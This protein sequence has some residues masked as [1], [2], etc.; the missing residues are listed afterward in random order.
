[1]TIRNISLFTLFI[2][3][4]FG[5]F[6]ENSA[7]VDMLFEDTCRELKVRENVAK[8]LLHF[9]NNAGKD[10]VQS[11]FDLVRAFC[12]RRQIAYS[13]AKDPLLMKS[14]ISVLLGEP[15]KESDSGEWVYYFNN[16]RT[17]HI[18]L[19]FREQTL[20]YTHYRQLK[21]NL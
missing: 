19:E 1:M 10:D 11:D 21:R 8:I 14:S 13:Q 15:H 4:L 12:I 18:S 20:F 5:C 16:D 3:L 6:Y 2:L 17:W 9:K 7:T